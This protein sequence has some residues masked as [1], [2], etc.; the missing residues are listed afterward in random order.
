M[1]AV[2]LLPRQVRPR[3]ELLDLV[4]LDG[5]VDDDTGL[6]G[7]PEARQQVEGAEDTPGRSGAP[8]RAPLPPIVHSTPTTSAIH[9]RPESARAFAPGLDRGLGRHVVATYPPLAHPGSLGA[10]ARV[11][12]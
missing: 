8:A 5:V 10:R 2:D 12:R 9:A 11:A 3:H 1:S 4:G 6:T 7:E